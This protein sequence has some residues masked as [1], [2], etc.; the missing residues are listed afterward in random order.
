M[1]IKDRVGSAF[2]QLHSRLPAPPVCP[3]I[4]GMMQLIG[5]LRLGA[6]LLQ[7]VRQRVGYLID[8]SAFLI[9]VCAVGRGIAFVGMRAVQRQQPPVPQGAYRHRRCHIQPGNIRQFKHAGILRFRP[10]L[11]NLGYLILPVISCDI[12]IPDF[13]LLSHSC[14]IGTLRR[15]KLPFL[16]LRGRCSRKRQARQCQQHHCPYFSHCA[17]SFPVVGCGSGFFPR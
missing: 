17:R 2:Q 11:G 16:F 3:G 9:A 13:R 15:K 8:G 5:N 1:N 4:M 10:A 14:Q 6:F 12:Y 7:G